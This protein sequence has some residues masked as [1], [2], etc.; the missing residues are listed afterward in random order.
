MMN[1]SRSMKDRRFGIMHQDTLWL[2]VPMPEPIQ[3]PGPDVVP[4]TD[5]PPGEAPPGRLPPDIAPPPEVDDPPPV[6][7]PAP[8]QEPPTPGLPPRLLVPLQG[9]PGSPTPGRRASRPAAYLL[10]GSSR[11]P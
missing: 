4:P 3:P 7:I 1:D 11:N 9:D 2:H 10:G 5:V 6:E 8:V